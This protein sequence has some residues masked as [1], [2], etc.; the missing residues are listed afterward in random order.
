MNLPARSGKLRRVQCSR[1][2]MPCPAMASGLGRMGSRD[3]GCLDQS[4]PDLSVQWAAGTWWGREPPALTSPPALMCAVSSQ[5]P[6]GHWWTLEKFPPVSF[7]N[8]FLDKCH[9]SS[10]LLTFL[11]TAR[12]L[13]LSAHELRFISVVT[14]LADYQKHLGSLLKTDF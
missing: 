10:R 1:E 14:S 6:R 9:P 11:H 12:D 2:W 3:S 7:I 8:W 4:V 13:C 5:C